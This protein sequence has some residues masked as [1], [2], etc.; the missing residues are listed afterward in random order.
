MRV[1]KSSSVLVSLEPNLRDPTFS[2]GSD[3]VILLFSTSDA[4]DTNSRCSFW[5]RDTVYAKTW[6]LHR[7]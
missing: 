3:E 6:R 4:A 7:H 2:L 1:L 5:L